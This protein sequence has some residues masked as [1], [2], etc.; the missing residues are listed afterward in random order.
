M[1]ERR[2]YRERNKFALPEREREREREGEGGE[3]D[4]SA[5]LFSPRDRPVFIFH[6]K[7]CRFSAVSFCEL[8]ARPQGPR[9]NLKARLGVSQ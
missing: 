4:W 9:S 8:Y 3:G 5:T 1:T 2:I 6:V 7:I